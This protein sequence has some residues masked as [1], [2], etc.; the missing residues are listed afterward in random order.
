MLLSLAAILVS[1]VSLYFARLFW[2]QTNRPVV[3]AFVTEFSAGDMGAAFNLVVANTGNRPAVRVQLHA[4][5]S[6]MLKLVEQ[7]AAQSRVRHVVGCF[8]SESEIPL[9]RNGE[10]V[11][12]SLGSV[13]SHPQNEKW[14]KYGAEI[15]ISITYKDLYGRSFKSQ[16]PIKIS[17]RKGFGGGTWGSRS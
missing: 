16:H 8:S 14:L 7:D 1:L 2:M 17:D 3:C 9:L 13:S 4:A 10:E 5:E 11:E 15:E 12:T 6:D